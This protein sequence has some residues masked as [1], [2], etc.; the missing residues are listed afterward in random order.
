[1]A[2][3][4]TEKHFIVEITFKK[5]SD[6]STKTISVSDRSFGS[7]EL[8]NGSPEII[9]ILESI[10]GFG[11]SMGEVVAKIASGTVSLKATRNSYA[12]AKRIYDLLEDYLIV[13]QPVT[14]YAF[15]RKR[16]VIGS[17]T[18]RVAEFTGT[19]TSYKIDTKNQTFQVAVQAK[20]FSSNLVN[21]R[22]S[23]LEDSSNLL[24][25]YRLLLKN[26]NTFAPLVFGRD[27][28]MPLSPLL[29]NN[30]ISGDLEVDETIVYGLASRIGD[31]PSRLTSEPFPIESSVLGTAD[32]DN[33]TAL[34]NNSK[35]ELIEIPLKRP[36]VLPNEQTNYI[37]NITYAGSE[38]AHYFTDGTNK[39]V[40]FFPITIDQSVSSNIVCSFL[41]FQMS[42]AMFRRGDI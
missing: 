5:I 16:D 21:K 12:F 35:N 8:Y 31:Y 1:M 39:F 3:S 32:F 34:V 15:E 36:R 14:C 18:D 37:T 6:A 23:N 25:N 7:G 27:V 40:F 10:S 4:K 22:Y 2:I 28:L 33:F 24:N 41:R 38:L 11:Q 19:A 20:N 13:D 42:A 17:N 29:V 30:Y 9:G 26:Q